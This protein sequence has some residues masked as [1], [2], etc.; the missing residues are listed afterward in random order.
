MLSKRTAKV[1]INVESAN[2]KIVTSCAHV[3]I[4][5]DKEDLAELLDYATYYF[6]NHLT[7]VVPSLT[8]P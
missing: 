7:V 4:S 1:G 6:A 8:E 3:I 2:L 5:K